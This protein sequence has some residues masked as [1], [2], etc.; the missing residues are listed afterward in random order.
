MFG[1]AICEAYYLYDH[2]NE[3]IYELVHWAKTIYQIKVFLSLALF[4]GVDKY[5]N[6]FFPPLKSH[7]IIQMKTFS[8]LTKF[9]T[10]FFQLLPPTIL[11]SISAQLGY[12]FFII[13]MS[14]FFILITHRVIE[15]SS[16]RDES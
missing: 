6:P 3:K 8:S 15:G 16:C 11:Q 10:F 9:S 2:V 12:N 4:L 1:V 13:I 14:I 5:S 7:K